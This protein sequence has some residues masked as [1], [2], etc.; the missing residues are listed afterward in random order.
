MMTSKTGQA[1]QTKSQ[2]FEHKWLEC[3]QCGFR[4]KRGEAAKPECPDCGAHMHIF[5]GARERRSK[6]R[7]FKTILVQLGDELRYARWFLSTMDFRLRYV[8]DPSI[9][10]KFIRATDRA[11]FVLR[12]KAWFIGLNKLAKSS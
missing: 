5:S 11:W 4:L 8:K 1:G 9:E 2:S 12:R 7:S 3:I 10:A 6:S